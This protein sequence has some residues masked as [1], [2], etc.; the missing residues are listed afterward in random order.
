MWPAQIHP[1][2][3]RCSS[4]QPRTA[5]SVN[6]RGGSM[7]ARS[8][9]WIVA[10]SSA[11]SRSRAGAEPLELT[12]QLSQIGPDP[13]GEPAHGLLLR[14]Q[15][16][17]LVAARAHAALH[18]RDQVDVL[19]EDERVER[20]LSRCASRPSGEPRCGPKHAQTS[21]VSS[22]PDG[23]HLPDVHLVGVEVDRGV[24]ID[25]CIAPDAAVLLGEAR[26]RADEALVEALA[27]VGRRARRASA[28]RTRPSL[29]GPR[30]G[31]ACSRA[32][33]SGPGWAIGTW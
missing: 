19:V 2:R 18:R 4:S 23:E 26:H 3:K 24:R 21:R 7:L 28:P 6:E 11:R 1:P 9:G 14:R 29:R 13:P 33:A 32:G 12:R 22:T 25:E 17:G 30:P 31:S 20:W 5:P 8:S 16:P 27:A 10:S 15:R